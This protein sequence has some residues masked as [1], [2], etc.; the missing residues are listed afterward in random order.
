MVNY[1]EILK[2]ILKVQISEDLEI[3]CQDYRDRLNVLE[4]EME[5]MGGGFLN[6]QGNDKFNV[7][8]NVIQHVHN[9]HPKQS[10]NKFRGGDN[11]DLDLGTENIENFLP[12]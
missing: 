9:T 12:D 7:Q 2:L 1:F 6:N 3:S 10:Q 5:E 4:R 11:D 8:T